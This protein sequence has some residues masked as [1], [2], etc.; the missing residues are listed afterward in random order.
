M[1]LVKP[2]QLP[3]QAK[4]RPTKAQWQDWIRQGLVDGKILPDGSVLVDENR[5]IGRVDFTEAQNDDI[6]DLLT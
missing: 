5:F 2:S 6:P 4:S 1:N 3:I